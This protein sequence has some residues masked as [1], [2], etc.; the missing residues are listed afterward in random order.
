MPCTGRELA[1]PP[2]AGD[3]VQ[4]QTGRVLLPGSLPGCLV[5]SRLCRV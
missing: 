3:L 2:G 5:E 4:G 1:T